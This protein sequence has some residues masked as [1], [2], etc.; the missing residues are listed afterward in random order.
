V[1]WRGPLGYVPWCQKLAWVQKGT[2]QIGMQLAKK[3]SR[4]DDIAPPDTFGELLSLSTTRPPCDLEGASGLCPLVSKAC[5][6]HTCFSHF[7]IEAWNVPSHHFFP[8]NFS[9]LSVAYIVPLLFFLAYVIGSPSWPLPLFYHQV[10]RVDCHWPN[11]YG[12][13]PLVR[14][15]LAS[16][17]AMCG[18]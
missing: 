16:S 15:Y 17:V 18:I 5:L 2:R 4:G 1:I 13:C 14:H 7:L 12:Y 6:D 8:S 9:L 10:H 11:R 3:V